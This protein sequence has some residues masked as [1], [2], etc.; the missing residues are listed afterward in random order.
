L[1]A[2][3]TIV[4]GGVEATVEI[5]SGSDAVEGDAGHGWS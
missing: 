1:R 4:D 3:A 5:G 2:L